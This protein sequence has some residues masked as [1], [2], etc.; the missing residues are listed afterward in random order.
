MKILTIVGARPQFIK[1]AVVSRAIAEYNSHC[2]LGKHI[3]EKIV[4]TGQHYDQNMSD[5][6]FEEMQ[7]PRPHYNLAIGSGSHAE[8]T[9]N[10][11]IALEK[12][13]LDE[14][15]DMVLVYGDT[16]ST[17]AG[18]LT[19]A[20]L[21]IPVV[22]VEA[23]LRSFNREMPEEINRI[24]TD[25]ISTLL[26]CPTDAA[27]DNLKN[28]GIP[29]NHNYCKVVNCGDTMNDAAIFYG[30]LSN[31]KWLKDNCLQSNNFILA[32]IHRAE[33]TNTTE[34][35]SKLIS[36]LDKISKE[37]YQVVWPMHPRT[38][39][40][41]NNYSDLKKQIKNSYI[42]IIEPIGYLDMVCAEKNC[43]LI[44]TDSGGVQKEAFF[45]K[46]LCVTMRTETEWIELV[47]TGW[48]KIA[49]LE[50]ENIIKCVKKMLE[51]NIDNLD[52][53]NLYGNGTAG[54]KIVK[55]LLLLEY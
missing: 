33:S 45:H 38:K 39:A 32:T 8:Q 3:E 55:E 34:R 6:F 10:M 2:I 53:P 35:L 18:S 14:K 13:Y 4:H 24:L 21:H 23:G 37:Y 5:I 9:G 44:L 42:R 11:M 54:E 22:H 16:N 47:K 31:N 12:V 17:L 49:G 15:P 30:S 26:I 27:V 50:P 40:M 7:I 43:R 29:N 19:A 25:Q 36:A 41:I 1:A 51:K 28:E 46:K 52:Y 48:N 20:K